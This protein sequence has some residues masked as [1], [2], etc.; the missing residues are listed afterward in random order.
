MRSECQTS[1]AKASAGQLPSL[2]S[3][4]GVAALWVVLFHYSVVYFPN[5][6]SSGFSGLIGKGYLA[7]DMFF[8]LSGFVMTHVYYR[9]FLQSIG[10]NYR[11]FLVARIARLYPLH[12][13]VLT[14]FVV[15]ALAA[16][17]TEYA[18]TGAFHSIPLTGPRSFAAFVANLFMLQGLDAGQLSWN[19]PAWSISV[20]FIAYL[21]FPFALPSI[22]RA[23]A[24]IK[25][26]LTALP[27][28]ALALFAYSAGGDFNQWDGPETLLRCLPEFML[29]T[30]LYCAFRSQALGRFLDGGAIVA[31]I[32]AAT[33]LSLHFAA[34]DLVSVLLFAVLILAAVVNTGRFAKAANVAPLI[35]LGDISYSIYL[36]HGLVQ[37][38]VTQVLRV[39]GITSREDLSIGVSAVLMIVMLA[40]CL[41]SATATYYRVETV[42]RRYLRALLGARRNARGAGVFGPE[43]P[44]ARTVP[45]YERTRSNIQSRRMPD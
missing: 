6:D 31:G 8:T 39:D 10:G 7:V 32:I 42:A 25:L 35:W 13:L 21:A 45:V 23:P 16:R 3:L 14:L 43:T 12:V 22:W 1:Q 17:L 40:I 30:L 36:I 41:L 15:A 26:A 24:G 20:E 37:F 2:T 33:L 28:A 44:I 5:L 9:A 19:Y 29:G 11:D 18:A 4:R 34:P 27:I 38:A